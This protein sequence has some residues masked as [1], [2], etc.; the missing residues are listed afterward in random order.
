MAF[1]NT[2]VILDSFFQISITVWHTENFI[3]VEHANENASLVSCLLA[4]HSWLI[5]AKPIAISFDFAKFRYSGIVED[6]VGLQDVIGE[7]ILARVQRV[8]LSVQSGIE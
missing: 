2:L 1:P 8:L 7:L 4:K 3:F 6:S 5:A